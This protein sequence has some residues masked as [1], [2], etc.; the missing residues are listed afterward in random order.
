MFFHPRKLCADKHDKT[1]DYTY[2][3]V[4]TGYIYIVQPTELARVRTE[5]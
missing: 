2:T 1:D 5:N 3:C 4:F